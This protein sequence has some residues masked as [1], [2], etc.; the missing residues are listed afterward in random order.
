MLKT[1][2]DWKCLHLCTNIKTNSSCKSGDLRS[3][4]SRT[5]LFRHHWQ[6]LRLLPVETKSVDSHLERLLWRRGLDRNQW[7]SIDSCEC[8]Y[9]PNAT[10]KPTSGENDRSFCTA[11][12][13][14][15]SRNS[16]QGWKSYIHICWERS[17]GKMA[18]ECAAEASHRSG[19]QC[20]DLYRERHERSEVG[21]WQALCEQGNHALIATASAVNGASAAVPGE[22]AG[23]NSTAKYLSHPLWP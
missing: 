5:E 7:R 22:T 6:T 1:V 12:D 16:C 11:N 23:L 19:E 3:G 15:S 4:S 8:L 20:R 14:K 9:S 10:T 21:H 18:R 13:N 17:Q 2:C